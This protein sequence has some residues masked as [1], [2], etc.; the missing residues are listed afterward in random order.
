MISLSKRAASGSAADT[1]A[2]ANSRRDAPPARTVFRERV[3]EMCLHSVDRR[4]RENIAAEEVGVV[5]EDRH[6]GCD[7]ECPGTPR[8][9]NPEFRPERPA[10]VAN[11]EQ[12]AVVVLSKRRGN[13]KAHANDEILLVAG[14][15]LRRQRG[16]QAD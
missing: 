7:L 10:I 2:T 16:R 4:L 6:A 12:L 8:L 11:V 1:S 13:L 9:G 15:V 5:T 14:E 3:E